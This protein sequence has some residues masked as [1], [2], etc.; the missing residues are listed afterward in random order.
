MDTVSTVP[1]WYVAALAGGFTLLG[2]LVTFSATTFTAKQ[3]NKL[4]DYRRFEGDIIQAYIDIEKALSMLHSHAGGTTGQDVKRT[5]RAIS[6]IQR[7]ERRLELIAPPEI[8]EIV[9]KVSGC[10]WRLNPLHPSVQDLSRPDA[11]DAMGE[12][13]QLVQQ[14]LRWTIRKSL[15]VG[16]SKRAI[17][18]RK[19]EARDEKRAERDWKQ[20]EGEQRKPV[21]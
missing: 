5:W 12:L 16:F 21:L 17:E 1:W 20:Y 11:S 6:D 14:D 7:H 19:K 8:E 13:V 9:K 2:A 15:R 10:A 4:D 18:Q 3:K